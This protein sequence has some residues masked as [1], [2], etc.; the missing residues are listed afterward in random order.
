MHIA[1]VTLVKWLPLTEK[2]L[3]T[4]AASSVTPSG[5]YCQ[6]PSI[7]RGQAPVIVHTP[8]L[9]SLLVAPCSTLDLCSQG[10]RLNSAGKE[11]GEEALG[12]SP[13][14]NGW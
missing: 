12:I 6:G 11:R 9:P 7:S 2:S 3:R 14:Q 1:L 10:L 8:S 13:F 5:E 4:A